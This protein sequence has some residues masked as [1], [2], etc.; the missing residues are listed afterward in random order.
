MRVSVYLPMLLSLL[1]AP[2]TPLLSRRLAPRLA[3]CALTLSAGLTA[4][5]S[6]WGLLLLATTLLQHTPEAEEHGAPPRPVSAVVAA[7]ALIALT[8]ARRA[9]GAGRRCPAR[10]RR[11]WPSRPHP[12]QHRPPAKHQRH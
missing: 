2:S 3:A 7:A 4:A 5:A 11:P 9:G 10:L 1:L 8:L 12:G 6:T